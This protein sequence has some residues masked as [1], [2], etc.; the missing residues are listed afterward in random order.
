[1]SSLPALESV[2]FDHALKAF[3]FGNTAHLHNIAL[4]K[5]GNINTAS[6]FCFSLAVF[7]LVFFEIS[8]I[9]QFALGF[10]HIFFSFFWY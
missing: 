4:V 9:S 10:V 2:S 1:M 7:V 5:N 8:K 6:Q 3:A